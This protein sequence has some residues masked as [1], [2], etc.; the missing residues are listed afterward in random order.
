MGRFNFKEFFFKYIDCTLK[1]TVKDL[2]NALL[3]YVF[4]EDPIEG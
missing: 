2:K 4:E 1:F 3:K